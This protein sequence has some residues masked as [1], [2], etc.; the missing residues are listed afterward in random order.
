MCP[1]GKEILPSSIQDRTKLYEKICECEKEARRYAVEKEKFQNYRLLRG[2]VLE[3]DRVMPSYI[4][5]EYKFDNNLQVN[6]A[7]V[8][9]GFAEQKNIAFL[10]LRRFNKMAGTN[11]ADVKELIFNPID[12]QKRLNLERAF[13]DYQLII[14]LDEIK[15]AIYSIEATSAV[16]EDV[17]EVLAIL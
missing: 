16:Y 12:Y 14:V 13:A 6:I 4:M 9:D 11:Y 8:K 1:I 17:R 2:R 10:N 5:G 15:S 7:S 3:G